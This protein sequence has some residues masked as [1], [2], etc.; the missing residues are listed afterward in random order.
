M[1]ERQTCI[2]TQRDDDG[3][4]EVGLWSVN[5]DALG[6]EGEMGIIIQMMQ[7]HPAVSG[8]EGVG[9]GTSSSVVAWGRGLAGGVAP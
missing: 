6:R 8:R 1:R 5:G 2:Q 9:F 3:R 7:Q 4:G